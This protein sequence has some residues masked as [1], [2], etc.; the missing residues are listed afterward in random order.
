MKALRTLCSVTAILCFSV[1][2]LAQEVHTDFDHNANF[3][4][5]RTYSWLR[6][7]SDNSLWQQR[8]QQD[9]D[10]TLQGLGLQMVASGGDLEVSAVGAVHNQQEYQTY[11]NGLGPGWYWGGFGSTATTAPINYRV[12]TLVVDMFDPANKQLI[13]RGTAADTLSEDPSKN[14]DKLKDAVHDMINKDKFPKPLGNLT[15]QD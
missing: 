6:V 4:K 1:V 5:Y 3:S 2:L 13:W 15:P 8:I 10:S 14:Q 9:I 12:G 7:Q 11:Y